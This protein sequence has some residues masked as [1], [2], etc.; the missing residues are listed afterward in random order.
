[1]G[2]ASTGRGIVAG[3]DG[4]DSALGAARW[5]ASI[6]HR[7]GEPLY[8]THVVP[9]RPSGNGAAAHGEQ[10]LDAAEAVVRAARPDVVVERK[11]EVGKPAQTLVEL[12]DTTRM[13]VLGHTT[14]SELQSMFARSDVVHTVNHAHCPVVTWRGDPGPSEL[15]G[16]PIFVGVDGSRLS[17]KA[18]DHAFEIA[19]KAGAPLTAVHTW[20]EQSTLTYGEG[21]RFT[22]WEA[23]EEHQAAE[24]SESL[25]GHREHYPDVEVSYRV[26]R[27]KPDV[28]L[29]EHSAHAQLVVVGS[30]GRSTIA[31]ALLGSTS[32]NLIHHAMCPVL[33]CRS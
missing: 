18:I 17:A 19:D 20:S 31:S 8:L 26:E 33:I 29:L 32:Q 9:E 24:L 2:R 6:A 7:F 4:S 12:S 21:S 1:M 11:I 27:G 30:H 5:A 15:D 16:A 28:T 14:T 22:D 23:Y 3:I 25:A 10:A 13:V